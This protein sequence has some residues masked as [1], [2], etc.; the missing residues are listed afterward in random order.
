MT[1]ASEAE[2]DWLDRMIGATVPALLFEEDAKHPR[3]AKPCVTWRAEKTGAVSAGAGCA[4][5]V[6]RPRSGAGARERRHMVQ[7]CRALRMQIKGFEDDFLAAK[8][9][10]PRGGERAPLAYADGAPRTEKNARRI[11]FERLRVPREYNLTI[12]RCFCC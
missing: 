2:L 10:A 3:T 11:I 7:A 1:S 6:W 5:H 9:H 12:G 8:G 4:H